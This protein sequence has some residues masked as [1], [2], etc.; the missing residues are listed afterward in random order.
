MYIDVKLSAT[1]V[2]NRHYMHER[3]LSNNTPW[4]PIVYNATASTCYAV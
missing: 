2:D 4:C 1:S 3:P